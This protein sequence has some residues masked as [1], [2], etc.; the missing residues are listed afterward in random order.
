VTWETF[1]TRNRALWNEA[2]ADPRV[3][4]MVLGLLRKDP[5]WQMPEE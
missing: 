5:N 3:E 1:E 4:G 2:Q